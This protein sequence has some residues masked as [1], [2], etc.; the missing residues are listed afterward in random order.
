VS[1]GTPAIILKASHTGRDGVKASTEV[2]GNLAAELTLSIGCRVILNENRWTERGLVNGAMGY[3]HDIVWP[4][5]TEYPRSEPP[6]AVLLQFDDYS[7]P[8]YPILIIDC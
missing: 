3:V 8:V 4:P 6:Y 5:E 2:A 7:G 1:L